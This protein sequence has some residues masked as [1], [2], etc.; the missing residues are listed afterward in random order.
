MKLSRVVLILPALALSAI[1]ADAA[2]QKPAATCVALTLP[3]VQGV[4]GNA[5]SFATAVRD[6]LASYLKGPSIRTESLESR[7]AAQAALEARDKNCGQMVLVTVQRK[8]A[9]GG[10]SRIFGQAA[11]LGLTHTMAGA[12]VTGAVASGA[13]LAGGEAI[14]RFASEIRAK[15][16]LVL[17]YR[18]GTPD[19][20]ERAKPVSFN[21]KAKS[22]G[23]DLLTPLVEQAANGIAATATG[24][25]Q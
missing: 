13:T 9:S 8:R 6:L 20:V 2:P 1:A 21:G 24:G 18:L 12:G 4:D 17:S 14:Y 19:A 10:A 16:E 25:G 7:L 11:G 22:D 3:S 5:T 23:E 15:D